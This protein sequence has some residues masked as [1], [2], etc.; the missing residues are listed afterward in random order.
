MYLLGEGA[1]GDL[2][3]EAQRVVGVSE[4][5]VD[6]LINLVKDWLDVQVIEAGKLQLHCRQVYIGDVLLQCS[7]AVQ[8]VANRKGIEI[9]ADDSDIQVL[10]DSER[11]TQ[12]LVNLVSNAIQYSPSGSRVI[13]SARQIDS[14]C[15]V[16]VIDTGPGISR[17]KQEQIFERY[18]RA[19]DDGGSNKRG[20][21]LGL[22]ICKDIIESHGGTIGVESELGRGSTF[23]FDVPLAATITLAKEESFQIHQ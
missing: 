16:S 18:K 4:R 1:F 13:M 22:A 12:V 15:R 10:A 14:M 23:W 5:E 2:S 9:E 6:R 8:A 21:G 19:I 17:D 11:L 7:E 3:H 20:A